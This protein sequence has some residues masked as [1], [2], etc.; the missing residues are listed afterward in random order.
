LTVLADS[1]PAT[2]EGESAAQYIS[3][4]KP[5]MDLLGNNAPAKEKGEDAKHY[6]DRLK[7][8][9]TATANNLPAIRQGESARAYIDRLRASINVTA[10][11]SAA[12]RAIANATR[13]RT[14]TIVVN[15]TTGRVAGNHGGAQLGPAVGG[16]IRG[17]GTGV[18][19]SIPAMLSNGEFVVRAA[20][21]KKNLAL[22]TQINGGAFVH[23][24]KNHHYA[25]GGYVNSGGYE[26]TYVSRESARA[27][28]GPAINVTELSAYDRKLLVDIADRV[29]IQIDTGTVSSA[30][31]TGFTRQTRRGNG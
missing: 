6:L 29:G 22:L 5:V 25:S 10:D 3:R 12:D 1:L 2:K 18:S 31:A 19:D 30:A 4:I 15:E 27:A 16:I 20:A 21:V 24:D 17:P 8:V 13:T 23:R 9:L 7:G 14:A 26:G 28:R 11:T